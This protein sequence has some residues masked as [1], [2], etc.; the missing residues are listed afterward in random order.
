MMRILK[1]SKKIKKDVICPRFWSVFLRKK[2]SKTTFFF[3]IFFSHIWFARKNEYLKKNSVRKSFSGAVCNNSTLPFRNYDMEFF[4]KIPVLQ[5]P[6]NLTILA[7]KIIPYKRKKLV[8]LRTQF[9]SF[10]RLSWPLFFTHKFE[11]TAVPDYWPWTLSFVVA[12]VVVVKK[13]SKRHPCS[14][15]SCLLHIW[16]GRRIGGDSGGG[17]SRGRTQ[18]E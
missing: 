6:I 7:K 17:R 14:K 13:L 4:Q 15:M 3:F 18:I 8:A 9:N 12:V 11:Y 5:I 10:L 1:K 16:I 2:S